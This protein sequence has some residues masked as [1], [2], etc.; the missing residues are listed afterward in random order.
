M[1]CYPQDAISAAQAPRTTLGDSDHHGTPAIPLFH[2]KNLPPAGNWM[3]VELPSDSFVGIMRAGSTS[4][5]HGNWN[6]S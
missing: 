5:I 3:Q 2:A 6:A 1:W 4:S